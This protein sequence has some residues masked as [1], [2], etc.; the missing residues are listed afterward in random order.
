LHNFS[1]VRKKRPFFSN[2]LLYAKYN[3][4]LREIQWFLVKKEKFFLPFNN[5]IKNTHKFLI[6]F[7]QISEQYLFQ[8]QN[9]LLKRS[10][11]TVI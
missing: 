3:Y 8:K 1:N 11:Q 2:I 5:T 4:I 9:T 6:V 7:Y 10:K